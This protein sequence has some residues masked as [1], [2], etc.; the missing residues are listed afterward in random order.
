MQIGFE[1]MEAKIKIKK[2][3]DAIVPLK[4]DDLTPA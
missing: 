3:L 1:K 4:R 2:E